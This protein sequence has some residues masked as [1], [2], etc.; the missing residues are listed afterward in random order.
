MK[1]F[2]V[3]V[4]RVA[5]N[6][7]CPSNPISEHFNSLNIMRQSFTPAGFLLPLI[8][9]SSILADFALISDVFANPFY[10]SETFRRHILDSMNDVFKA[11]ASHVNHFL[12]TR[13][14][15]LG[16]K[17]GIPID[18][19]CILYN[20]R[21]VGPRARD[22]LRGINILCNKH[23]RIKVGSEKVSNSSSSVSEYL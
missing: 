5:T 8:E 14:P 18:E 7:R 13:L 19:G 4:L 16:T 15:R 3:H 23:R 11:L 22:R 1:G 12:Q 2:S 20:R 17:V 6:F 21:A 10:D 9:L